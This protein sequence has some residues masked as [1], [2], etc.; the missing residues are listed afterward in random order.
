MP[1]YYTLILK[2]LDGHIDNNLMIN[3]SVQRNGELVNMSLDGEIPSKTL[4]NASLLAYGC[5]SD[6]VTE[7]VQLSESAVE[8]HYTLNLS[9]V[10]FYHYVC[11]GTHD[12][13][14]ISVSSPQP[15][16]VRV[17]GN[18]IN[19]SM[20]TGLLLV[21]YSLTNDSDIH[22]VIDSFKQS[23]DI[24]VTGLT[25]TQYGISTFALDNDQIFPRVVALPE[26]VTVHSNE[27]TSRLF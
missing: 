19:G 16:D 24:N 12:I 7:E 10:I 6:T 26:Y 14:N 8:I 23:I 15:G 13:Q 20:A 5:E 2:P 3:I 25:G 17:T 4:W 9:G 27:Q 1:S 21:L 22:Y 11:V 18:Y